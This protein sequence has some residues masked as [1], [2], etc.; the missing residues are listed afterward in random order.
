MAELSEGSDIVLL[1]NLARFLGGFN[2]AFVIGVDQ[3]LKQVVSKEEVE[4]EM[5]FVE[6][7]EELFEALSVSWLRVGFDAFGS[8]DDAGLRH[9]N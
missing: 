9:W 6:D 8:H 4:V 7:V 1:Q 5:V 3:K 2:V